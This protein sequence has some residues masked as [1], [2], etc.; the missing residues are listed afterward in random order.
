MRLCPWRFAVVA[1]CASLLASLLM[2]LGTGCSPQPRPEFEAYQRSFYKVQFDSTTSIVRAPRAIY[3]TVPSLL[4]D[5][6]EIGGRVLELR[7]DTLTMEPSYVLTA[8]REH[9]GEVRRIRLS[10]RRV[11]PDFVLI[12]VQAGV[13][14][15]PITKSRVSSMTM[16]I[17]VAVT[18]FLYFRYCHW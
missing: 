10:G 9:P 15:E 5:V 17:L 11:L 12:P 7:S 1:R 18:S 2:V 16:P 8:D 4:R 13:H 3:D 6:V 14:I